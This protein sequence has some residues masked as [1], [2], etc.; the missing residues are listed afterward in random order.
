MGNQTDSEWGDRDQGDGYLELLAYPDAQARESE[1]AWTAR[2]RCCECCDGV[3]TSKGTEGR[4]EAGLRVLKTRAAQGQKQERQDRADPGEK[5]F[6][7]ICPLVSESPAVTNLVG[8]A[9]TTTRVT[10]AGCSCRHGGGTVEIAMVG[11]TVLTTL[12]R[13]RRSL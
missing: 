9:G 4:I 7:R 6:R 11:R 1:A 8:V 12:E 13:L 5:A 3:Q 2:R 10:T